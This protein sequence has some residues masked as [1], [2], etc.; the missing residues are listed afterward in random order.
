V[1]A[2]PN[3]ENTRSSIESRVTAAGIG[4]QVTFTGMLNSTLKWSALRAADCFVLPSYSEG[5]SVSVLEAMGMGLPVIITKQC[6][7]PE[8]AELGCGWVIEPNSHELESAIDECLAASPSEVY[9][10]MQG[11][12]VPSN[13]VVNF[14]GKR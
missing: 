14:G 7:L 8:V 3:F 6:N 4:D 11:G 9:T 5:L 13:V 10:W 1:L 2:G 12:P